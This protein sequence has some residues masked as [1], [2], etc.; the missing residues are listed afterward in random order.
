VQA[1][2]ERQPVAIGARSP[3]G[4]HLDYAHA[5]P[6][7][8][9]DAFFKLLAELR[10]RYEFKLVITV[11]FQARTRDAAPTRRPKESMLFR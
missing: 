1:S 6:R 4:K 2:P 11:D 5:A 3:T 9:D 10:R 8:G 7:M